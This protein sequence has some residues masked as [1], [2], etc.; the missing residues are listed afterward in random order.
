L[1][2]WRL[3]RIFRYR[4]KEIKKKVMIITGKNNIE[5]FR[6]KM[7]ISGLELEIKTGMKMSRI[8]ARDAAKQTLGLSSKSRV[9][10]IDLYFAMIELHNEKVKELTEQ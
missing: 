7:I 9:Q 10:S 5:L 4:K 3:I 1:V 2:P 6:L 8:S